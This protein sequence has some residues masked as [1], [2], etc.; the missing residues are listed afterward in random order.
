MNEKLFKRIQ[1]V[2]AD[3]KGVTNLEG[4][5]LASMVANLGPKA[6][7]VEIGSFL[8]RS[9]A[10]IA[11]GSP[12]DAILYMID[13]WDRSLLEIV[14]QENRYAVAGKSHKFEAIKRLKALGLFEKVIMLQGVSEV[15]AK[16]WKYPIDFLFIDGDHNYEGI[17]RDYECWSPFVKSGS[18]IAFHDFSPRWPGVIKFISRVVVNDLD[19]H[20]LRRTIWSGR[21]I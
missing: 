4:K 1:K 16:D 20:Q 10:Y 7:I 14:S 11:A 3:G 5:I 13:L 18:R 8:G 9:S 2:Y 6:I 19:D 15:F 12:E 17:S 21:K